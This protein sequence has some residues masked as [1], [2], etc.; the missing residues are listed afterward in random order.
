MQKNPLLAVEFE[1]ASFSKTHYLPYHDLRHSK[2]PT[3][4][5]DCFE[6]KFYDG[7]DLKSLTVDSP[8]TCHFN[9]RE[10]IDCAGFMFNV[11]ASGGPNCLLKMEMLNPTTDVRYI[12]GTRFCRVTG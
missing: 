3:F 10:D 5:L 6:Y 2:L 8:A 9:C 11:T 12:S 7:A 1:L 4:A